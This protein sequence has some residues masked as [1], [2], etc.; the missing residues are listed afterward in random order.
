MYQPSWDLAVTPLNGILAGDG[1][2]IAGHVDSG[3]LLSWSERLYAQVMHCVALGDLAPVRH[4]IASPALA[5]FNLVVEERRRQQLA[6]RVRLLTVQ[7]LDFG[8]HKD[9]GPARRTDVRLRS[10]MLSQLL[11]ENRTLLAGDPSLPVVVNEVWTF[12]RDDEGP[13]LLTGMDDDE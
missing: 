10:T 4:L 5:E 1:G 12:E 13:W 6:W 9:F 8:Y 2:S 7:A 3:S 11:D